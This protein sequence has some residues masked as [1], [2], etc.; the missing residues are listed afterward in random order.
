[1]ANHWK[2]QLNGLLCRSYGAQKLQW[3]Q[4]QHGPASWEVIALIQQVEY[5]RGTGY[6]G[7]A[8]KEDAAR[9]AYTTLSRQLGY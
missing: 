7:N 6:T 1:M 3:V 8:A 2:L 9:H 5:G 4:H